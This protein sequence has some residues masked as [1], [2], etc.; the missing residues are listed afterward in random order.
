MQRSADCG[1]LSHN[2]YIYIGTAS[3]HGSGIIVGEQQ[4]DSKSKNAR[5]FTSIFNN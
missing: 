4:K 3:P 2:A 1:D 5:N